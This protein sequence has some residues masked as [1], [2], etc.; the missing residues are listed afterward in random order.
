[1][2]PVVDI[3]SG[4]KAVEDDLTKVSAGLGVLAA[5]DPQI[6][7]VNRSTV[8][9]DS[10]YAK[11]V[12]AIQTQITRDFAPRWK[13][14]ARVQFVQVAD[15]TH[16]QLIILDTSDQAGVLGYHETG[17]SGTPIGYVFAKTDLDNGA[18]VSVTM[19]HEIL[20]MLGDPDINLCVQ[21]NSTQFVAA[22]NAD[23]CEADA[24]G[25]LIGDVLVSDFVLPAYFQ[26]SVPGPFDFKNWLTDRMPTIRPEGY[27]S[28]WDAS[29]GGWTQKNGSLIVTPKAKFLARPKNGSRR[30]RRMIPRDQW[31]KSTI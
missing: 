5:G 28:I 27:L 30:A 14:D 19:S 20:E 31:L 12:V 25:Y 2:G 17:I 26:M 29:A 10:E 22:E 8:L 6:D 1:M 7:V 24:D 4:L 11:Y 21:M 3:I 9:S 23:C 13:I 16:W 15:P 18:S